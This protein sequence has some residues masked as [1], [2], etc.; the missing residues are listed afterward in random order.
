VGHLVTVLLATHRLPQPVLLQVRDAC[1]SLELTAT[2]WVRGTPRGTPRAL[3]AGLDQGAR[4]IPED[5]MALLEATPALRLVLCT[6]E[7]LIKPRIVLGDGRICVLC[8]PIERAQLVTAL[9][10]AVLPPV[11]PPREGHANRRFEVLRRSHWIAWSRG[12]SG[13]AIALHEQRGATVV[14]GAAARDPSVVAG[15]MT[16]DGSD[17]DREAALVGLVGRS[18]VAHLSHDAS[19]WIVYWPVE[20]CPLWVYSPNRLPA[21]WNAARGVAAVAQRRLLRLPAFPHDQLVGA[22]SETASAD[23]EVAPIRSVL[24]DGGP[25]TLLGLDELAGRHD[26]MTGLIVEVR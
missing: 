2:D 5:V 8:P 15:V 14:V 9:R 20:R 1:K 7:P 11:P 6:Q 22:W 25:D 19:E 12:R 4:R 16:S 17:A 21:C 18:G 13:P 23:A 24:V 26:H 10:E 3:V